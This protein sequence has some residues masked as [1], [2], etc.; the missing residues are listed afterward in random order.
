MRGKMAIDDFLTEEQTM[1]RGMVRDFCEKEVTPRAAETDAGRFPAELVRRMSELGL[2]GMAVPAEYGGGGVDAVSLALAMEEMSAACPS[3][4]VIFAVQ[5]TLVCAPINDYGTKAQKK[6]ILGPLA[7]GEKLGC[8]GLTEPV[9]G[10]DAAALKTRAETG[11]DGWIINGEKRFISVSQE[12][13]ICL[14]FAATDLTAGQPG[15]GHKSISVFIAETGSPGFEVGP[16]EEKMGLGG[17]SACSI[18]CELL[19]LPASAL[20]GNEGQGLEIAMVTLDAGRIEVAAQAAGFARAALEATVDYAR[21]RETFGKPLSRH[22][23]VQW[24]IADMATEIEAARLLYLKAARLKEASFPFS[25]EAAIA[26][27]FAS[28]M[29]QRVTSEAVQIHGGN[30][31]MKAYPVERYYRAAKVTQIYEGANEILLQ[32]IAKHLID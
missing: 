18:R 6:D 20:L 23:P 31:Y 12:A 5:N 11:A 1:V 16:S 7:R 3:L 15:S 26:K 24:K 25:A 30:G 10:S 14:I 22:Q 29:A 21:E 17:S 28:D 9:T 13:D 27:V 19:D 8:F 32:L 2:L 4:S